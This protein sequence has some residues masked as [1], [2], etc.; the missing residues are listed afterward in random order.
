MAFDDELVAEWIGTPLCERPS[1]LLC[2]YTGEAPPYCAPMLRDP[3]PAIGVSLGRGFI[4]SYRTALKDNPAVHDG[5]VLLGRRARDS[6]YCVTAWSMRLYP[7]PA[8]QA[9]T[10]NRGSAF[11]SCL[12]MSCVAG[13]DRMYMV[14]EGRLICFSAGHWMELG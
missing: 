4:M 6:Q 14:S 3:A 11:N 7:P 2:L 12:E 13:V 9:A 10:A 5:A 8:A 1:F